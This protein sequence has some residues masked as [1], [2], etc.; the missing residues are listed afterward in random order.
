MFTYSY[1]NLYSQSR[2]LSDATE[3][4]PLCNLL[5][6][7]LLAFD[8]RGAGRSDGQLS[9]RIVEDLTSI[10][11]SLCGGNLDVKVILWARGMASYVG[12]QYVTQQQEAMAKW[13]S[14]A[15]A[16]RMMKREKALRKQQAR[17]QLMK[18]LGSDHPD[19]DDD[20]DEDDEDG[21][22]DEPSQYVKFIVLD[23]PFTSLKSVVM[24]TAKNIDMLGTIK[25]S[26]LLHIDYNFVV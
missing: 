4:L 13:E 12:V 17:E 1:F 5:N 2:C 25:H 11:Q 7:N 15:P 22:D 23:S 16:R 21:D 24:E 14:T 19:F 18:Q 3:L 10:L 26:T 8:Q 20:D 6:A 9:F